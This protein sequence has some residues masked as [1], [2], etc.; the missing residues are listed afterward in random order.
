MIYWAAYKKSKIIVEES[1]ERAVSGKCQKRRGEMPG[2]LEVMARVIYTCPK[3][4]HLNLL[5]EFPAKN[6][7][8]MIVTFYPKDNKCMDLISSKSRKG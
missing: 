1:G 4:F 5:R 8:E 2:I 6:L 7:G 3:C